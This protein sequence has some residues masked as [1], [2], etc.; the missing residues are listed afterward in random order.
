MVDVDTEIVLC[1]N[2]I[3][4]RRVSHADTDWEHILIFFTRKVTVGVCV[5]FVA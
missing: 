5:W 4:W 2:R 3:P 1:L